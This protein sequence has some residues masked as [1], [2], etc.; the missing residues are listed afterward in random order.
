MISLQGHSST[1][2]NCSLPVCSWCQYLSYV[3]DEAAVWPGVMKAVQDQ[4]QTELYHSLG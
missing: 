4:S 3:G 1:T 2:L